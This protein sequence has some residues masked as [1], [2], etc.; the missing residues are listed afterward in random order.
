MRATGALALFL[1]LFAPLVGCSSDDD[2][3]GPSNPDPDPNPTGPVGSMAFEIRDPDDTIT[4]FGV[5]D[6]VVTA[7]NVTDAAKAPET[8]VIQ[9][10]GETLPVTDSLEELA[11]GDWVA[12]ISYRDG[13][14]AQVAYT[15]IGIAV[16]TDETTQ[17]D[18]VLAEDGASLLANWRTRVSGVIHFDQRPLSETTATTAIISVIDRDANRQFYGGVVEYDT[19]TG[20]FSIS[21]VPFAEL[22][23]TIYVSETGG[24]PNL[25]GNFVGYALDNLRGD[26][27]LDRNGLVFEVNRTIHVTSPADMATDLGPLGEY[28]THS[29][30]VTFAWDEIPEAT[31]YTYTLTEYDTEPSYTFVANISNDETTDISMELSLD[32]IPEDHVYVFR[33]YAYGEDG[34]VGVLRS[35][36]TNAT[37]NDYRFHVN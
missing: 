13:A 17:L 37:G 29:T 36:Y 8:L 22:A 3:T 25:P 12:E 11:T 35:V 30:P 14:G 21:N 26:S 5:V 20:G 9:L 16:R 18:N 2:P 15:E 7:T 10:R 19:S 4:S 24:N 31:K 23:F 1:L 34:L 32:L 28:L 6:A 27:T 33:I